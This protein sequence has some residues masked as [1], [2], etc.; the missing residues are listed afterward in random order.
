MRGWIAVYHLYIVK[1]N[2]DYTRK[3]ME[4]VRQQLT[5]TKYLLYFLLD[6]PQIDYTY[7]S[8]WMNLNVT[9]DLCIK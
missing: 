5:L 8:A 9:S 4:S 2:T 3:K 1:K 6:P 7:G